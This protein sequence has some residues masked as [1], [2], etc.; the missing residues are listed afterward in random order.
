[1]SKVTSKLQVT[2]PR[3]V[4]DHYGIRPGDEVRWE[5]REGGPLMAPEKNIRD[6][7][8]A[9]ERSRQFLEA[10]ERVALQQQ[11]AGVSGEGDRGWTRDD[12]YED[13]LARPR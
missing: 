7:L 1:M 6:R 11:R 4:A 8:T 12:L 9:E 10:V 3:L 13:R 2:I 5:V